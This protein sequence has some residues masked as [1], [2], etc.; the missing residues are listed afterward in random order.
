MMPIN[1]ASGTVHLEIIPGIHQVP[2]IR[3][4][5]VYLIED[6][7]LVLIDTGLPWSAGRVL[8]Y[9]RSIGRRPEELGLIL[10]THGHPD[11]VSGAWAIGNRT[12]AEVVAH[13]GD[14]KTHRGD[15]VSLSY[16]G[17]F[18]SLGLPL[19][20]L[21]RTRV[22]NLA[23]DGQ[24]LPVL[25]GLR[26]LHTPGHTPGSVCYVLEDRGVVFSGDTLFS[27]G[28]RVSRSVPFPGYDGVS[29]R[30][31]LTRL[32]GLEFD[33]LCG[34]HGEP[35]VG[36][37]SH[38]LRQLLEARPDPPTWGQFLRQVPSR[39]YRSRSLSGENF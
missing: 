1:K 7:P 21:R 8:D 20:F 13:R 9:V 25:G 23:A 19:P 14:T 39:L 10:V 38:R 37:A 6:D 4:S 29:Y 12:G 35:L 33:V 30:R 27:D 11:H 26:V 5:R 31:S 28:K 17:V 34:G 16:M 36:G 15:E 2:G 22:D 18:G 3:W 32:A 24:V